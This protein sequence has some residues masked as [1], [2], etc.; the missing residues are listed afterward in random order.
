MNNPET[1]GELIEALNKRDLIEYAEIA[2]QYKRTKQI[3]HILL[4][5]VRTKPTPNVETVMSGFFNLVQTVRLELEARAAMLEVGSKFNALNNGDTLNPKTIKRLTKD[6]LA[7]IAE[8]NGEAMA[9]NALTNAL[10]FLLDEPETLTL[11]MALVG[12]QVHIETQIG[13]LEHRSKLLG[14]TTKGIHPLNKLND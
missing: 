9:I 7:D 10:R 12:M 5:M 1:Y 3:G 14:I 4:E 11:Q 2:G 8:L 13:E 6:Q